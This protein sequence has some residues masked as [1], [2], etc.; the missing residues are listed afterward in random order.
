MTVADPVPVITL[1]FAMQHTLTVAEHGN[2]MKMSVVGKE[3]CTGHH[4]I[5]GQMHI[6]MHISCSVTLQARY[7]RLDDPAS[8]CHQV[9]DHLPACPVGWSWASFAS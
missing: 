7:T 2:C 1:D 5:H 6:I 4:C 9:H 3:L 8:P